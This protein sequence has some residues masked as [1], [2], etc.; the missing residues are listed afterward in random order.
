ME[1]ASAC[2]SP[3]ST[4]ISVV[5]PAPFGPR[6]P[7]AQPRGTS[8]S[9]S[10]TATFSPKRFVRP[11]VSTAHWLPPATDGGELERVAVLKAL[12]SESRRCGRPGLRY[13]R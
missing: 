5:L 13:T 3:S 9:T 7:N 4:R 2:V 1:P 8:S 12:T 11:W 6:Y 10:F